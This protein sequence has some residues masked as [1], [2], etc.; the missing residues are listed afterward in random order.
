[1]NLTQEEISGIN[2]FYTISDLVRKEKKSQETF[3][4]KCHN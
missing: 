1:M 4:N 2:K 3:M